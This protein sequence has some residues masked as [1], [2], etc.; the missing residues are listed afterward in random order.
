MKGKAGVDG[1]AAAAPQYDENFSPG[2]FVS[3][4]RCGMSRL[5]MLN[6]RGMMYTV[7]PTICG[8][9]LL[10][11]NVFLLPRSPSSSASIRSLSPKWTGPTE[12]S[13]FMARSQKK[14]LLPSRFDQL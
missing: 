10:R 6:P 3:F 8:S 11:D 2:F 1:C 5:R 7:S 14:S 13:A 9:K 4:D 12:S